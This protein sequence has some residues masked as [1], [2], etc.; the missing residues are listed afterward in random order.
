MSRLLINIGNTNCTVARLGGEPHVGAIEVLGRL[1]TPRDERSDVAM[2]ADLARFRLPAE[3][4]A[5]VSVIPRVSAALRRA[6]PDVQLVDHGW[7]FPFAHC[8]R[9]PETVGADRWCNVAAATGAGLTDALIVDAGTATTIDVLEGGIFAGGLIAPGM[10]FAARSLQEQAAQ[11]WP[12]PFAA[13]A[14]EPGRDTAEALQIGA[15]H[16]GIHGVTGTVTAL[17]ADRLQAAVIITGG[18]GE[19]LQ[20]EGW[21]FDPDW[22][23]RGLALLAA[24]REAAS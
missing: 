2:A 12:V 4:V 14:L 11:L 24:R 21:R 5:A 15:F 20:R 17:L 8:I 19:F 9:Q 1:P 3:P 18:L 10:A 16:A 6:L 13:C 22:T 7:S 23:L